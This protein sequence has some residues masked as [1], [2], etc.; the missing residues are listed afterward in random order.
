MRP[1]PV[2]SEIPLLT[3]GEAA[4]GARER[5]IVEVNCAVHFEFVAHAKC[6][7]AYVADVRLFPSV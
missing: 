4:I 5:L 3:E 6:L 7:G 2:I 1:L